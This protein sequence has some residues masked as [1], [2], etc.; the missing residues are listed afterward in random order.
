MKSLYLFIVFFAI[1]LIAKSQ[2]SYDDV[3]VIIN[4]NSDASIEIGTYF[5]EQRGIPD[6][7]LLYIDCMDQE[8]IDTAEFRSIANQVKLKLEE[9]NLTD[10]V[11]Y[12]VTTMG[13]P[14]HFSKDNN[15]DSIPFAVRCRS[16]DDRLSLINSDW[17]PDIIYQNFGY[18]NPYW[19]SQDHFNSISYERYLVTRLD[20]F[21]IDSVKS[22]IDRSGPGRNIVKEDANILVDFAVSD[23]IIPNLFEFLLDPAFLFFEEN[24]W[25]YIYSPDSLVVQ[26]QDN[27]LI[28]Y[29]L[30][31][32]EPETA[33][34]Y[35]WSPGAI[36]LGTGNTR[37]FY[38]SG[39]NL[40]PLGLMNMGAT[41]A[42]GFTDPYFF[43]AALQ[44]EYLFKL[45]LSDTSDFNLAESIYSSAPYVGNNLVVIGD[46]KTSLNIL[47]A[48]LNDQNTLSGYI[49]VW[50]N[51][52]RRELNIIARSIKSVCN[53]SLL[54]QYGQI[55]FSED[56]INLSDQSYQINVSGLA[57][58]LYFL[59]IIT[60]DGESGIAKCLIGR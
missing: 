26:E 40:S 60:E 53:I 30:V 7:N 42:A 43:S 14:L 47:H 13:I 34:I 52:A 4:S 44:P 35:T 55:I 23:T 24:N 15:C 50:P 49:D 20:G 22:M 56:G 10:S 3:A 46:P 27:I 36:A 32:H 41:S 37:G 16:V 2:V 57:P 33:P 45:Y 18:D 51:P 39:R 59:R 29:G 11:N 6:E 31:W 58:G 38:N 21:S 5:A 28:Y 1:G 8:L 9:N 54:N 12:L 25:N 17:I 19:K 48:G